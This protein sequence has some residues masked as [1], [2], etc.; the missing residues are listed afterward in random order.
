MSKATDH[1]VVSIYRHSDEQI[2]ELMARAPECV[3]MWGTKDGW[4]MGV[5]HSYLWHDGH[6]WIT[7]ASHRHRTAA[8]RR[9]PRVSVTVSGRTS[10]DPECPMGAVTL[11]GRAVFHDDRETKDWFYRALS[12]KGYPDDP[13]C[14]E[15]FYQL[16]DS[17]LRTVIEVTPEKWISF[18]AEKSAKHRAGTLPEEELSPKLSVDTERLPKE[19]ERRGIE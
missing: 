9:D 8:I 19:L 12:K 6:V 16:L 18:D 11:K 5:V 17:P 13:A 7:F 15:D 2:H 3:L 4:P 14:E 10:R 1:E